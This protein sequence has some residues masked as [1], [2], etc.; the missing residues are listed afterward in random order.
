MTFKR[1]LSGTSGSG[2]KSHNLRAILLTLLHHKRVSRVRLARITGLSTTTITNLVGELIE[3]E[4]VVEEGTETAPTHRRVGRPR[5]A[6]RLVPEAR[7]AIGIHIG[8]GSIRVSIADLLAH[9]ILILSF[10]HPLE[11]PVNAVL[12]QIAGVVTNGLEQTGIDR[13]RVV[14]VGVGA[15][16][17]VDMQSGVNILAPNLDWRAVPLRDW[18]REHLGFPVCVDNNVRAMALAEALFGNGREE[19]VLAFVYARIGV[20][21]GF[22]VDGELFRGSIAGA[23]EIGHTTIIANGGALCRCGNR[24]CLETLVSEPVIVRLAHELALAHPEGILA[25]TLREGSGSL[26]SRVFAAA[27]AGDA[28]TREMLQQRACY[29][30][31]ALANLVNVLNPDLIVLGGIFSQGETWLVPAAEAMMRERAFGGLGARVRLETT[32]FGQE[33]GAIGAAALALNRFFYEH[34]ESF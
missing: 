21:A 33:V 26:I 10:N 6:L 30:G 32:R 13:S 20:G 16:G 19:R 8:V 14:G 28:P 31:I 1:S 11:Q 29:M 17:L 4:V 22:V 25:Q 24:G 3:E 5:T 27:D 34:S 18:F 2:I 7:Y 9:P 12:E 23:G 15:S